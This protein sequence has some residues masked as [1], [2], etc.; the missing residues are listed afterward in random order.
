MT[1]DWAA[2]S[3]VSALTT[4][5]DSVSRTVPAAPKYGS[6]TTRYR[7]VSGRSGNLKARTEPADKVASSMTSLPEGA[8]T[9]TDENEVKVLLLKPSDRSSP[10]VA[11][12]VDSAFCPHRSMVTSAVGP[13]VVS[14]GV[15]VGFDSVSVSLPVPMFCGFRLSV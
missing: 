12:K 6:I 15:T 13:V 4:S 8:S 9:V 2:P 14:S 3:T 11:W 5:A 1:A 10:A 7:P